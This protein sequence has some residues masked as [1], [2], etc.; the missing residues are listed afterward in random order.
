MRIS[1]L[2]L[3][4]LCRASGALHSDLSFPRAHALGY[5]Y[6]APGGARSS[7]QNLLRAERRPFFPAEVYSVPGGPVSSLQNYVAGE[8]TGWYIRI[9][10]GV[11]RVFST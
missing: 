8:G 4:L 1:S 3:L 2:G 5:R 7:L 6:F 11:T 9:L 10:F